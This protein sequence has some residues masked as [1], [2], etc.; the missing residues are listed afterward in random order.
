MI[1]YW[2]GD[3]EPVL[4]CQSCGREQPAG[5]LNENGYCDECDRCRIC[6]D[7]FHLKQLGYQQ[8]CDNCLEEDYD[9]LRIQP[10]RIR[11]T[12]I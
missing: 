11:R 8:I 12:P 5:W 1:M 9:L 7:W 3:W 4:C 6:G 2:Y 10:P